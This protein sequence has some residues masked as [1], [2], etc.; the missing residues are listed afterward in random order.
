MYIYLELHMYIYPPKGEWNQYLIGK[1]PLIKIRKVGR[2]GRPRVFT[3]RPIVI[4][5]EMLHAAH[6][7]ITQLMEIFVVVGT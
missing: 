7:N 1:V 6:I 2:S 5:I 4:P 3:L